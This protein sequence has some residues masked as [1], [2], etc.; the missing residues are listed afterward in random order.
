[1]PIYVRETGVVA[2]GAGLDPGEGMAMCG[3]NNQL[4]AKNVAASKTPAEELSGG[5]AF[6][7]T[8]YNPRLTAPTKTNKCFIQTNKGGNNPC[9]ARP[10][11]DSVLPNCVG[12][13]WGRVYEISTQYHTETPGLWMTADAHTWYT[14]NQRTEHYSYGDVPRLGAIIC[15][16]RK[17]G[18]Y[19]G[20]VGV[21][22]Q[23]NY[24]K[25][26][27]KISSIVISDSWS[28]T[29]TDPDKAEKYWFHL[30]TIKPSKKA[31]GAANYNCYEFED[32]YDF[33][34][35]MYPP[36]V[37]L[38]AADAGEEYTGGES[39]E[40]AITINQTTIA[41]KDPVTGEYTY[42]QGAVSEYISTLP[43]IPTDPSTV[44]TVPG[45]ELR[46]GCQ[47]K[48]I[49]SGNTSKVGNGSVIHNEGKQGIVKSYHAGFAYPYAVGTETR[50]W[51]YYTAAALES[52]ASNDNVK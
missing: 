43:G 21:V 44:P 37:A 8:V 51:G 31:N 9:A 13:A 38:F 10:L 40:Q 47:V 32:A 27:D 33:Q 41:V 24:N 39:V 15:Y 3:A 26:K 52:K 49:D 25:N 46:A 17:V 45:P 42:E 12:Y 18:N 4:R 5:I 35:F 20:H 11:Y 19:G 1:M 50:T 30:I 34:G 22:E 6:G 36:Y 14:N 2:T 16:K 48:I 28:Y 23:I 7:V 29:G